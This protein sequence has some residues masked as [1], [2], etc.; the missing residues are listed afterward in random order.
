MM[1][2]GWGDNPLR[3]A[4][5]RKVIAA[6]VMVLAALGCDDA[7]SPLAPPP[8]P[9]EQFIALR[10]AGPA[11]ISPGGTGQFTAIG[12]RRDGTTAD[13]TNRVNWSSS[14]SLLTFDAQGLGHAKAEGRG[15]ARV[16]ATF[17]GYPS[18]SMSVLLLEPD[19]FRLSG[20]VTESGFSISGAAVEVVE[21]TGSGLRAT[22]DSNGHYDLY[23]VAGAIRLRISAPGFESTTATAVVNEHATADVSLKPIVSTIDLGGTW[24]L[25]AT[26]AAGCRTMLPEAAWQGDIEVVIGHHDSHPQVRFPGPITWT[27]TLANGVLT[28]LMSQPEV[29]GQHEF[30]PIPFKPI[31]TVSWLEVGGLVTA[32]VGQDQITGTLNGRFRLATELASNSITCEDRAHGITMRRR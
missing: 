26:A 14:P 23:G 16:T 25:T 13:L 8:S 15:E 29:P 24:V 6:A 20:T 3:S 2:S 5:K 4:G 17:Q 1:W 12:E 30:P 22:T 10:L 21:G 11:T 31:T 9:A 32:T 28:F 18:G 27:G 7:R 19:T